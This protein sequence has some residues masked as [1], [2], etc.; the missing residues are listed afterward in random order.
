[1][2]KFNYECYKNFCEINGLSASKFS[3]LKFYK[4]YLA[5]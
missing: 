2:P 4:M 3:S 5:L 1:M